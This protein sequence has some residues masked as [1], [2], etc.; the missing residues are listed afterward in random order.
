MNAKIVEILKS[1]NMDGLKYFVATLDNGGVRYGITSR[2]TSGLIQ[3][4]L[5]SEIVERVFEIAKIEDDNEFE[6]AVDELFY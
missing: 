2:T 3:S 4:S 5:K 6:E 1:T